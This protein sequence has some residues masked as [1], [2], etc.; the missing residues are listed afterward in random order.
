MTFGLMVV[1]A[2]F[3]RAG[4]PV[5]AALAAAFAVALSSVLSKIVLETRK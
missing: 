5:V 2:P 4:G 3:W 1:T